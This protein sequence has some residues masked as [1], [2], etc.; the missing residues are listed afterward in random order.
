MRLDPAWLAWFTLPF[1][2]V[3]GADM[4]TVLANREQ[5]LQDWLR[6]AR[7]SQW[8][9][10]EAERSFLKQHF[11]IGIPLVLLTAFSGTTV[12]ASISLNPA[13]WF[14]LIVA[15]I[16]VL[17]AILSGLQTFLR[18]ADRA[19]A[20][21]AAATYYSSL[22]RELEQILAQPTTSLSD[23]EITGIREKLSE[24]AE[25]SPAIPSRVWKRTEKL[26]AARV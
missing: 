14:Q 18:N 10:Y 20:H 25:R 21:R 23:G 17:A 4:V 24:L 19:S 16:T 13:L 11:S 15:G 12:F 3:Y 26:I 6:R 22:R 9:H 5:L 1:A 2:V 8:A 7:E